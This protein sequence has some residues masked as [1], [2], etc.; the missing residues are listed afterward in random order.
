MKIVMMTM[1]PFSSTKNELQPVYPVIAKNSHSIVYVNRSQCEESAG[2][3]GEGSESD[4]PDVAKSQPYPTSQACQTL[5]V[6]HILAE[7]EV[8]CINQFP[9]LVELLL[10][11]CSNRLLDFYCSLDD[12]RLALILSSCSSIQQ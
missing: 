12:R 7:M 4:E 9:K 5:S 8:C 1:N 10:Q 11:M 3:E 2:S 6:L